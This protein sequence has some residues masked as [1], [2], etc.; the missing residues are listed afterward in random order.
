MS[1]SSAGSTDPV[2][3]ELVAE[4]RGLAIRGESLEA[5]RPGMKRT[6]ASSER[7]LAAAITAVKSGSEELFPGGVLMEPRQDPEIDEQ[8]LVVR[9]SAVGEMDQILSRYQTW[10]RRLGEWATG[11]ESI[12][13]LSVDVKDEEH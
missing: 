5:R 8:Y 13:R 6:D 9:V 1:V 12:F 3:A 10:H 7:R 11:L 4:V 2:I